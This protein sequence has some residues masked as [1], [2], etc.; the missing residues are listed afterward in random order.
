[1]VSYKRVF[2]GVKAFSFYW[3]KSL[4][5]LQ[6]WMP[7]FPRVQLLLLFIF[8][9]SLLLLNCLFAHIWYWRS[10]VCCGCLWR[11]PTQLF[12]YFLQYC[13]RLIELA[14][15]PLCF[16]LPEFYLSRSAGDHTANDWDVVK[17]NILSFRL[18]LSVRE[19]HESLVIVKVVLGLFLV[20]LDCCLFPIPTRW[21]FE[22][23]SHIVKFLVFYHDL[24][25][26]RRRPHLFKEI[27]WLLK[28]VVLGFGFFTQTPLKVSFRPLHFLQRCESL[29]QVVGLQWAFRFAVVL[30]QPVRQS[31]PTVSGSLFAQVIILALPKQSL[32]FHWF[33]HGHVQFTVAVVQRP[34]IVV[35]HVF[36]GHRL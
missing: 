2:Y 27:F 17:W 36:L 24:L 35:F 8:G 1:M 14:P 28:L 29:N 5:L 22:V 20:W 7:V 30:Q 16:F 25:V 11:Q 13:L 3:L 26:L 15:V 19:L 31:L 12:A 4:V 6:R 23:G 18:N 32:R 33:L 9:R 10:N 34:K 21:L